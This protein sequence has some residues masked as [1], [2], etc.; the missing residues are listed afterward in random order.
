MEVVL[1]TKSLTKRFKKLVAVDN[2]DLIVYRGDVFGF[3]GPNGAGK[4]T[5]IR[6]LTSLIYPDSGEI[7]LFNEKLSPT[8]K[9]VL[10]RV[11]AIVESPDFY[12]YLTAYKNLEILARIYGINPTRKQIMEILEFVGLANRWNSKV[13]TFSHGMKQRLGIAQALL[14]NP[15]L[16]IL[17][18]PTTGLDPYGMKEIRDLIVQLAKEKGKTV[19]LS[20]HLLYEIEQVANRM[21][22]INNGKKIIE[23]NVKDLLD[24]KNAVYIFDVSDLNKSIQLL[25]EKN[26]IKD[27]DYQI[28]KNKLKIL[29]QKI[30]AYEL[31]KLFVANGI[32]VY[33]FKPQRTLEEF[34]LEITQG[35]KQ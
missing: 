20:S 3:L 1:Q 23:G 7:F 4:S 30:P 29:S 17:D 35:K 11:G 18:E 34:F 12:L 6:M 2:L 10:R 5:T 21:I 13:K 26:L 19:F 31:N 27:V 9:N 24:T 32:D 22:I 15:D 25:N 28:D 14:H 16:I 33:S 8:N